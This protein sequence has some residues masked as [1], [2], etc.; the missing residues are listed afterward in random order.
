MDQALSNKIQNDM[1]SMFSVSHE[2]SATSDS[3]FPMYSYETPCFQ[4]WKGFV[5]HLISKG[6]SYDEIKQILISKNVRYMFD[7]ESQVIEDLGA[8]LA[9]SFVS[10]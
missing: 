5:N 3:P 9:E 4:F 10:N 7:S 8:K 6:L 1:Y 2:P